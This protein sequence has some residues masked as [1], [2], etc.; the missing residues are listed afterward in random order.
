MPEGTNAKPLSSWHF[1][2]VDGT[3][4]QVPLDDTAGGSNCFDWLSR[5]E[6]RHIDQS[7]SIL[8]MV[9]DGKVGCAHYPAGSLKVTQAQKETC[10]RLRIQ[11]A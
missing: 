11:S 5:P 8:V 2:E 7:T 10:E 6:Q 4:H 3:S 9:H 1:I